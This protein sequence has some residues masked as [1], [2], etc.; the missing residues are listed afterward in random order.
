MYNKTTQQ[1]ERDMIPC[2]RIADWEIWMYDVV[3]GV[4]YTNS[5]SWTFT[6]WPDV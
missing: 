1:Y 5:W 3:N 6:K 2:Y 4:F